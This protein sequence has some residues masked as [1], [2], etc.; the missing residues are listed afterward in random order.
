MRW[1]RLLTVTLKP[2]PPLKAQPSSTGLR[3]AELTLTGSLLLQPGGWACLLL[4]SKILQS[5]SPGLQGTL[6]TQTPSQSNLTGL[7]V[8]S[9]LASN[10]SL[11]YPASK[12]VQ[13]PPVSGSQCLSPP[14]MNYWSVVDRAPCPFL[15][16]SGP[17]CPSQAQPSAKVSRGS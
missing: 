4:T 11:P 14:C 2:L 5:V 16:I 17:L 15:V 7:P 8:F 6:I 12:L 10:F 9:Y 1:C 13:G 3:I